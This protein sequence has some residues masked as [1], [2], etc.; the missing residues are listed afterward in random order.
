M[1]PDEPLF[2][3]RDPHQLFTRWFDDAVDSEP[4]VPDAMQLATVDAQGSPDLR[5]VL[6]KAHGPRGWVFYTNTA[7]A[8]GQQL[9]DHPEVCAVLHWKSR[10]RQVRV[11]GRATLLTDAEADAY[12]ATRPRGSQL[13]AWASLQ[14][15]A[16][17]TPELLA[18]RVDEMTARFAGGEVPRPP[19]WSGYRIDV[20]RFEFW[21]GR[22][23]RLHDRVVFARSDEGWSRGMLYP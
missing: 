8:K 13:G 5:T 15:Q 9:A 16:L 22:P 23:S 10:Q 12:H 2:H 19:G 4:D 21:Q 7:S 3:L 11:H 18:Q 1:L 17:A 6:L 20:R 14:S